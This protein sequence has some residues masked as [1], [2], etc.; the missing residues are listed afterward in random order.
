MTDKTIPHGAPGIAGFETETWGGPQEVLY[1][2]TPPR[3][4]QSILVTATGADLELPIYSV[5]AENGTLA[6]YTPGVTASGTITFSGTGD[7]NDTV[8][9]G[10]VEYTLVAAA[11]NAYEVAIGV[12]ASE[13]AANLVAAIMAASGAG[14]AYGTGTEANVA[15]TAAAAAGVV[16]ATAKIEGTAGN[17]IALAKEGN[18]IAVS[19]PTLLGGTAP[20][21]NAYGILATAADIPQGVTASV[22][23]YRTGHFNGHALNW[24]VSFST[25]AKQRVAF[26]NTKSPGILV[27]H[28]KFSDNDLSI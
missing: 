10:G 26:D 27:S 23:V 12:D 6:T 9:V 25:P 15:V 28:K 8:T 18:D 11:S 4:T 17:S 19:D 1:G 24:D 14:T 13:T 21:S 5:I 2:D 16:T 22:P 3:A 7:P 20:S